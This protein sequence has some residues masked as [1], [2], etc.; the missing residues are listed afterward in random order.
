MEQRL[1]TRALQRR[2]MKPEEIANLAVY[3]ASPEAESM[4]GQAISLDGGMI[5]Q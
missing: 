5:M 4:T 1:S 2:R 3:L